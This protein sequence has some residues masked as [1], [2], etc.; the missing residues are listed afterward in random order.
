VQD[1]VVADEGVVKQR[2]DVLIRIPP[3]ACDDVE[4]QVLNGEGIVA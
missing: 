4:I 3:E 1:A 2:I